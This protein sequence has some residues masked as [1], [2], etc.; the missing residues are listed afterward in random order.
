MASSQC[1]GPGHVYHSAT[2]S[3][4]ARVHFG[5]NHNYHHDVYQ[6][7]EQIIY[8]AIIENLAFHDMGRRSELLSSE[9]KHSFQWIIDKNE[10]IEGSVIISEDDDNPDS[11]TFDSPT[12]DSYSSDSSLSSTFRSR[13]YRK[14]HES[15]AESRIPVRNLDPHLDERGYTC[16]ALRDW[17]SSDHQSSTFWIT[18]KPGSGKSTLTKAIQDHRLIDELLRK[19]TNNK[20]YII[21]EHF[22]WLAGDPMQRSLIGM[23]RALLCRILQALTVEADLELLKT[24][25]DVRWTTTSRHR[26]WDYEALKSS[27]KRACQCVSLKTLFIIDGLDECDAQEHPELITDILELG[28]CPNVKSIVSS[29][30]R[31][32]FEARLQCTLRVKVEDI[33][34][35]DMRDFAF[36]RL[37]EAEASHDGNRHFRDQSIEAQSLVTEIEL[38]AEGVFLWTALV[39]KALATEVRKGCQIESLLSTMRE[40]PEGLEQY[41]R[42]RI[43]SRV[44]QTKQNRIDTANALMLLIHT[45]EAGLSHYQ[46]GN[47]VAFSLLTHRQLFTPI[48]SSEHRLCT[49][50][51]ALRQKR[52]TI[53]FLQETCGDMVQVSPWSGRLTERGSVVDSE[54]LP[55]ASAVEFVHRSAFDFLHDE[56][57]MS[58][59]V[60]NRSEQFTEAS[61]AE[62]I[63]A[64]CVREMMGQEKMQCDDA[65]LLLLAM[66][67]RCKMDNS[68]WR[69]EY[70]RVGDCFA[71]Q[72]VTAN[73]LR[74]FT[75]REIW[76]IDVSITLFN[77][78]VRVYA[79]AVM[80]EASHL[81]LQDRKLHHDPHDLEIW[82]GLGPGHTESSNLH[83]SCVEQLL[84]LG[85]EAN[86][87]VTR[88]LSTT[89]SMYVT[90]SDTSMW[91]LFL[92]KWVVQPWLTKAHT[93]IWSGSALA[94]RWK[95]LL[96]S[97]VARS[98][99]GNKFDAFVPA[100]NAD[101]EEQIARIA[102]AMLEAGAN[103]KAKICTCRWAWMRLDH[104][105]ERISLEQ[106]IKSYMPPRWREPM[107]VKL[108]DVSSAAEQ[109]FRF[110]R[111]KLRSLR[112]FRTAIPDPDTPSY[113]PF[114]TTT[115]ATF[116][117]W[118]LSYVSS[119]GYSCAICGYLDSSNGFHICLD[120]DG[121]LL[122]CQDCILT[123]P[124]FREG[125]SLLDYLGSFWAFDSQIG[126]KVM[127]DWRSLHNIRVT[128][129]SWYERN[130]ERYGV[131]G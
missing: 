90:D 56:Q 36:R 53:S 13:G 116:L 19:W 48:P 125:H 4:S 130:A 83:L 21:A 32:V 102:L 6:T 29:R 89:A 96:P 60:A 112:A 115:F 44:P 108:K 27:L 95:V 34:S 91:E 97:R 101:Q 124:C 107:L 42:E 109:D 50:E 74:A 51:Q 121:F 127:R 39:L 14:R 77:T 73:K 111:Q 46:G 88:R 126:P 58:F 113:I 70:L 119:R 62:M 1:A 69:L 30:P 23:M 82:L 79:L 17:L 117:Q 22:F 128:L 68:M 37:A 118:W 80:R 65:T 9:T 26:Q 99:F 18:G 15:K 105:C 114:M 28:A 87:S 63:G 55:L 64:A 61:V 81:I 75:G 3:G 120:C 104:R 86:D 11:P 5:D 43:Y 131:L 98:L 72:H 7:R 57:T 103:P 52:R 45:H 20:D 49:R 67:A 54:N 16:Q 106:V 123:A 47:L 40:Y 92:C 100:V 84:E 76:N 59:I 71:A 25:C 12:F 33:T 93:A 41:F 66:I 31:P 85:S 129:Y 10:Q 24:I 38:R 110:K 8:H 35:R 122:I 78:S 2:I 94:D